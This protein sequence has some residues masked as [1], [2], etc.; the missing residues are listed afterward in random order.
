[1]IVNICYSRTTNATDHKAAAMI[2]GKFNGEATV[3]VHAADSLDTH[4]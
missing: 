4:G 1:M 3:Q 2:H